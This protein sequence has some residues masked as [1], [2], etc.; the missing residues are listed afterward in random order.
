MEGATQFYYLDLVPDRCQKGQTGH[1][2]RN[3]LLR[4]GPRKCF[5]HNNLY[6]TIL[7]GKPFDFYE[8]EF[9]AKIDNSAALAMPIIAG[10]QLDHFTDNILNQ[11]IEFMCVQQLRTPKG[12]DLVVKL[13]EN[14][15]GM[16]RPDNN[17]VCL[18]F[19]H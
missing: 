17:V 1:Y 9:M 12:L 16:L 2:K 4:W 6:S 19:I 5:A 10:C 11:F 14:K 3:N 15:T 7:R 8:R 18:Y 13:I